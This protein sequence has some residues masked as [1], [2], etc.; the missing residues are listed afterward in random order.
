[1]FQ[2][3]AVE[4]RSL[5]RRLIAETEFHFRFLSC[6]DTRTNH[7]LATTLLVQINLNRCNQQTQVKSL[8]HYSSFPMI[9]SFLANPDR[10]LPALTF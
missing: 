10:I 3:G 2:Q 4:T 6:S 8:N 9:H 5:V 7:T 1:M